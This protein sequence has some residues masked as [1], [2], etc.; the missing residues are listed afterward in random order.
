MSYSR[1]YSANVPYSGSVRYSYPASQSGGTSSASYSGTVQVYVTINV[2]TNPFDGS[3]NNFNRSVDLLSGSVVAMK[4]AHCAAIQKAASDVSESIIGGFFG[5]INMEL[6][7]QL[8][9]LDSAINATLGLLIQQEKAV[10]DKKN[11]MEGDYHRI[12]SRY[13]RLFA[14]LDNECY[15]RIYALDKQSFTLSEKVQKELL[16]ETSGTAAALNLLGIEEI[17]SSKTFVLISSMNRK[18]LEVL[19]TLHNYITQESKMNTLVESFLLNEEVEDNIPFYV[20]VVWFESD[21]LDE[22]GVKQ[23]SIIPDYIDQ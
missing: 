17:S 11:V 15:K 21:V 23:E 3:V 2:D 6:S 13:I 1:N 14:D 5:T 18:T 16:S 12:S 4:A 22:N 7:Q 20:P 9:A 10:A 19:Q 8:Q